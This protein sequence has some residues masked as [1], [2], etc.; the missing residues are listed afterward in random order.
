MP[1]FRVT[2]QYPY[3]CYYEQEVEVEATDEKAAAVAGLA[4]ADYDWTRGYEVG[5]GVSDDSEVTEVERIDEEEAEPS[6]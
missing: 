3:T 5:D 4:K 6:P 1:K 2:V